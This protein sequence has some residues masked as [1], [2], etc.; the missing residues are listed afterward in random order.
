MGVNNRT[1][2]IFLYILFY[3]DTIQCV[4]IWNALYVSSCLLD[5]RGP[6][7]RDRMVIGFTTTYH[8]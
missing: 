4:K 5:F 7:G 2:D 1:M 3:L 6:P 8:H